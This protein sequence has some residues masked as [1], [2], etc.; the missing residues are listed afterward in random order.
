MR[1]VVGASRTLLPTTEHSRVTGR[2]N[3]NERESKAGSHAERT[4]FTFT[5]KQ[6]YRPM[7]GL[8]HRRGVCRSARQ[9]QPPRCVVETKYDEEVALECPWPSAHCLRRCCSSRRWYCCHQR[10]KSRRRSDRWAEKL[11]CFR[12]RLHSITSMSSLD[13][14]TTGSG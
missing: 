3:N 12:P 11:F 13:N 5:F 14:S 6:S 7:S 10:L 2:N 1:C 4:L 8:V 9:V